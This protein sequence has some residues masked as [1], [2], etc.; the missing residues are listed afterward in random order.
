MF[1]GRQAH[2]FWY[3]N[4]AAGSMFHNMLYHVP[5]CCMT[6]APSMWSYDWFCYRHTIMDATWYIIIPG[7]HPR[8]QFWAVTPVRWMANVSKCH[9]DAPEKSPVMFS[10]PSIS[11]QKKHIIKHSL[12]YIFTTHFMWVVHAWTCDY[13]MSW[14]CHVPH[15]CVA[16]HMHTCSRRSLHA[17]LKNA[18]AFVNMLSKLVRK[19]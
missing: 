17:I 14:L 2:T 12:Q 9:G 16:N 18:W 1:C 19:S 13:T 11:W 7:I 8:T 3:V 4:T 10:T 15:D 6:Y 5:V